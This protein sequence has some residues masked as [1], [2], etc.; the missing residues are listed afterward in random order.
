MT[1]SEPRKKTSDAFGFLLLRSVKDRGMR[2]LKAYQKGEKKQSS[3][4]A[5]L[6][7]SNYDIKNSSTRTNE[8]IAIYIIINVIH[9]EI[10]CS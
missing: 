2:K 5:A 4:E 3:E 7:L 9:I 1:R 10:F 6:R 8:G